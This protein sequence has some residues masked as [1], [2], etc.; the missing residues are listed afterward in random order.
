MTQRR[1]QWKRTSKNGYTY[2]KETASQVSKYPLWSFVLN[3][4]LKQSMILYDDVSY[5]W[6]HTY[7]LNLIKSYKENSGCSSI[8][9]ATFHLN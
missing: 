3:I 8:D 5:F 1:Q 4:C 7:A 9:V 2:P 6:L